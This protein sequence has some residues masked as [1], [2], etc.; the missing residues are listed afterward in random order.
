MDENKI[1][2]DAQ[3]KLVKEYKAEVYD[4]LREQLFSSEDEDDGSSVSPISKFVKRYV[5]EAILDPTSKAA[6]VL[7]NTIFKDNLLELLDA[8]KSEEMKRNKDFNEY[9]LVK[10]FYNHQRDIILDCNKFR[11]IIAIT[12]RRTGKTTMNAGLCV[13][14]CLTPS[15]SVAYINLTFTNAIDQ[16][17][18][19]ILDYADSIQLAVSFKSKSEGVIKFNNGSRIKITGNSNNAEADKLRGFNCRLAIIDE[20]GHQRNID[21]LVD[22]ILVPQ[23]ADFSDSTLLLTGTPS[24]IPNHF[25]TRIFQ[26]DNEYKKY[27]FTMLDN[28]FIPNPRGLI[29][30]E[31]AN[32]GMGIDT[33]FIRRE[34][35]GEFVSDTEA[36]VFKDYKYYTEL[37]DLTDFNPIG[38]NIGGD[39]GYRDYNGIVTVIYNKEKA[40]VLKEDKFNKANVSKIIEKML[41][42]Y[43]YALS[44]NKKYGWNVPVK[45][46]A[47]YN[48][49]SITKELMIKYKVPAF[50]CYKYDR[51]YAIEK[52]AEMARTG[53]LL[54]PY[55]GLC[56]D[57]MDRTLYERDPNTDAIITELSSDY[58]PDI[59]MALLYASRRM[60]YDMGLDVKY[61]IQDGEEKVV[62]V[63]DTS[64][65]S[66]VKAA[67]I[68]TPV[69]QSA[70]SGIVMSDLGT[71]G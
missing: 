42:H 33:P 35:F 17:F 47:D 64:H 27:H 10:Q 38:I 45:I 54:V 51:A 23:M 11:K 71:I 39:Y 61:K 44:L 58:H 55:Q 65:E 21:Y 48:E 16:I 6:N 34:Y 5:N 3:E 32:K 37:P 46:Y 25:S 30:Q 40:L 2:K 26:G 15:S 68:P 52:L 20:I 18:D 28:P 4:N 8:D 1:I 13:F 50:N 7:A 9:R 19:K 43:D 60:F 56:A 24:R 31:A 12:S 22:E 41:S 14:E 63:E 29:E 67:F 49:E 70:S 36:I 62:V 59:L 66:E 57:E 69:T 53:R